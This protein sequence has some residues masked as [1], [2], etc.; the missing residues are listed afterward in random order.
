[1][2][3]NFAISKISSTLHFYN[4]KGSLF[5]DFN[6]AALA[7]HLGTFCRSRILLYFPNRNNKKIL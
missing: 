2:R 3:P 6:F 4:S 7:N 1:M 5:P